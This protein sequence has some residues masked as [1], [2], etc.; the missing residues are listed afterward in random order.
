MRKGAGKC[1][2]LFCSIVTF[3]KDENENQ[4]GSFHTNDLGDRFSEFLYVFYLPELSTENVTPFFFLLSNP[5]TISLALVFLVPQARPQRTP[6]TSQEYLE[7]HCCRNLSSFEMS[8]FLWLW[9]LAFCLCVRL[10]SA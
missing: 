5:H 3:R 6:S 1:I 4:T 10:F 9:F 2:H 7:V 8:L